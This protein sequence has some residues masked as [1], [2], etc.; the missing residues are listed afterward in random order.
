MIR[1]ARSI[2]KGTKQKKNR[3]KKSSL[4]L[5]LVRADVS[6]TKYHEA[7]IIIQISFSINM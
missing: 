7:I 3:Q 6:I 5:L 2:I 1:S 4:M